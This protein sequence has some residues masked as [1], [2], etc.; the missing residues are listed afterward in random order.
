MNKLFTL[1]LPKT[2]KIKDERKSH[3][4]FRAKLLQK[5]NVLVKKA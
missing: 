2:S 1:N 3:Y 4:S 5:R